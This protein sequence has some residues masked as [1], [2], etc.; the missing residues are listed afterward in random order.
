VADLPPLRP[1]T[2]AADDPSQQ[3]AVSL[4]RILWL[5][6]NDLTRAFELNIGGLEQP[7]DTHTFNTD[8][9][10]TASAPLAMIAR[11]LGELGRRRGRRGPLSGKTLVVM[12]SEIGRFPRLNGAQGKDHFPE[13]PYVIFGAG[14]GRGAV[15]GRAGK[16]MAAV[17]VSTRT[18]APAGSGGRSLLLDDLGASLLHLGGVPDPSVYGYEGKVLDFLVGA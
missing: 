9:Q 10:R 6:E 17:P 11:F 12:G 2:W 14:A 8:R 15:F 18:G 4:Q 16:D 13:A 1:A 5:F 3:L 7:W